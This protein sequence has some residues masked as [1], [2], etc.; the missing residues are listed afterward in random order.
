MGG[1]AARQRRA[2][3]PVVAQLRPF[4]DEVHDDFLSVGTMDAFPR[5][6]PHGSTRAWR[7]M[8]PRRG[9]HE[10]PLDFSLRC[11][12]AQS[13]ERC[14][15][16]SPQ[17]TRGMARDT[18]VL[19]PV[20]LSHVGSVCPRATTPAFSTSSLPRVRTTA[21]RVFSASNSFCPRDI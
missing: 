4:P 11:P 10:Q 2:S 17:Q 5:P 6:R 14:A 19:L 13:V 16:Q 9:L 18:R 7:A 3:K 8:A 15:K 12:I 1:C 20:A 21:V